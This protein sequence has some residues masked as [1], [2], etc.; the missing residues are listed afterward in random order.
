MES[1]F[2]NGD[3]VYILMPIFKSNYTHVGSVIN[4]G[5]FK[6]GSVIYETKDGQQK[7]KLGQFE[8]CFTLNSESDFN[9]EDSLY[10]WLR[11]NNS[12]YNKPFVIDNHIETGEVYR[13]N[14][15]RVGI[16]IQPHET[17]IKVKIITS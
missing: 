9:I 2:K 15:W 10:Y 6:D 11:G 3:T 13:G 16:M 5:T 8:P 4:W 14:C 1:K 12:H 7:T 17:E